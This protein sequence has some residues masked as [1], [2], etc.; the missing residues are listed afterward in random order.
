MLMN[1]QLDPEK[2]L[3]LKRYEYLNQYVRPGQT[4]FAGS[5]LMEQFPIEEF[6]LGLELPTLIYNRGVGGFTTTE[7]MEYLDVCIYQLKPSRI[8]L[9]IG[10]NDMNGDDY[11]VEELMERYEYMVKEILSHLPKAELTLLAY[12]PVNHQASPDDGWFFHR[13]NARIREANQAVE[14]LAKKYA[15]G[16]LNLNGPITDADGN[17]KAEYTIDG[18][19][20]YPNGYREVLK[21]LLPALRR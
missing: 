3:K 10:T 17:L 20:M 6:E 2:L 18:V 14:A 16:F 1:V 4:L 11:R 19:H 9:N 8:F 12:Y 21:E 5:S 13:T 15:L 7:M